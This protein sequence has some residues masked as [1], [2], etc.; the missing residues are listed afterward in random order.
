MTDA[1]LKSLGLN[2]DISAS[3]DCSASRAWALAIHGASPSWDGFRNVSRQMNMV[4]ASPIFEH[5]APRKL[6]AEKLGGGRWMTSAIASTSLR[7]DGTART[8]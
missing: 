1:A 5:S 7:S 4:I 8:T 3:A 6:R 2:N